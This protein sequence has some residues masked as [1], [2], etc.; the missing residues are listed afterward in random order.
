MGADIWSLAIDAER[1]RV[2]GAM[3]RVTEDAAD[4]YDPTL[5]ADGATLVFRS[6][7]AGRFDVV[8]RILRTGAEAV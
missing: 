1:G 6:R 4:D 7:R 3:K 2:Q 5:S 8:A